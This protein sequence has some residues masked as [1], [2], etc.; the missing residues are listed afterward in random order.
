MTKRALGASVALF[1][2]FFPFIGIAEDLVIVRPRTEFV[3]HGL[4]RS[5]RERIARG[6]VFHLGPTLTPGRGYGNYET[7]VV[8][9]QS[10]GNNKQDPGVT[11]KDANGALN[12]RGYTVTPSGWISVKAEPADAEVLVDGHP[13]KLDQSSGLSQK[14][15]YLVGRHTIEVR[16]KGL[17]PYSGEIELRPANDVHI[18]VKLTP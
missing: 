3:S 10:Y 17:E 4:E 2:T 9:P 16:K 14:I 1:I 15:G 5:L 6:S 18:D 8:Y 11:G 12:F 13:I 7:V